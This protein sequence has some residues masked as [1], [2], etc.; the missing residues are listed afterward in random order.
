[1]TAV[2]NHATIY[3]I[4]DMESTKLTIQIQKTRLEKAKVFAKQSKTS[5]SRLVNEFLG[6][7]PENNQLQNSQIVS[8]L[9]GVLSPKAAIADYK[10]HLEKKYRG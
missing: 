6:Q 1:L 5:L 7:L 4:E 3:G 8:R 2:L 9:S 10:N